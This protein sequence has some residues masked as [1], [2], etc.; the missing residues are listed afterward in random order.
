MKVSRKVENARKGQPRPA[1]DFEEMSRRMRKG[2]DDRIRRL[3][4]IES[5]IDRKIMTLEKLLDKAESLGVED[6]YRAIVP[7]SASGLK[8]DDIARTLD[9]SIGEVELILN[10]ER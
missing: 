6:H 2:L 1:S 3:M 9:I 7:L 4:A 5:K 10:M 8:I